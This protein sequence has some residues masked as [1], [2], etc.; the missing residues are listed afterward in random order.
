MKE[1]F[2]VAWSG[3]PQYAVRSTDVEAWALAHSLQ[4]EMIDG[5]D[6]I[7]VLRVN[8]DDMTIERLGTPDGT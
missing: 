6:W 2:V 8:L 4:A 5:L 7:D 1:L 3:E